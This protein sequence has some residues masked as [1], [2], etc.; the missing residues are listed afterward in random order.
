MTSNVF[1]FPQVL[2]ST[3]NYCI[4]FPAPKVCTLV[5]FI[6]IVSGSMRKYTEATGVQWVVAKLFAPLVHNEI[7]LAI[8]R[9]QCARLVLKLVSPGK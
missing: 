8:L 6:F 3:M 9:T 1:T 5:L 2:Y 4:I 7:E